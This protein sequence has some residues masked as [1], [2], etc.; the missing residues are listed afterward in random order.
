MSRF[1][2]L[3]LILFITPSF[4]GE[5]D[6]LLELLEQVKKERSQER[7]VLAKRELKFKKAQSKQKVLLAAALKKL[8]ADEKRSETLKKNYNSYDLEI[9]RQNAVLKENMGSLGELDGIVKQIAGD[10]DV[11][12]DTSL[13][14]AQKPDR[15]KILDVLSSRKELPSLQELEDLWLLAMDEMVES[16]RVVTFPGKIV[17]A[18]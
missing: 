17:T 10:L 1:I 18:A 12:I 14:S 5:P 9:S 6:S 16:G 15:D 2:I 3:S 11:I 13:V 7:E 4:A 8:A